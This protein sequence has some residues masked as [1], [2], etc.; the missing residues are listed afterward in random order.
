MPYNSYNC[1]N[2]CETFND[3][4]FVYKSQRGD[5][6]YNFNT[7][8]DDLDI[9]LYVASDG[10]THDFLFSEIILDPVI[11][12]LTYGVSIEKIELDN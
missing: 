3:S 2:L 7:I 1:M 10:K 8:N 4:I 9:R 12:K 6:I 5:I 11:M